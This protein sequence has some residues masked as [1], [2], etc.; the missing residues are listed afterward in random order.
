[1]ENKTKSIIYFFLVVNFFG[2]ANCKKSK[3]H[4]KST[5]KKVIKIDTI[6]CK[7]DPSLYSEII[8]GLLYKNSSSNVYLRRKQV[9]QKSPLG[10]E[11]SECE[12][13]PY[14]YIHIMKTVN[15]SIIKIGDV[16]DVKTFKKLS[17]TDVFYS[18]KN[19]IY[20]FQDSPATYPQFKE[21]DIDINKMVI[22]DSLYIKDEKNVYWKGIKIP[23]AKAISLKSKEIYTKDRKKIS[24]VYDGK[25]LYHLDKKYSIGQFKNLP[26]NNKKL[27]SLQSIYF[28]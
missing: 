11:L 18:D 3:T 9:V 4:L 25:S 28:K 6:K 17:N 13:I 7:N 1:M 10:G 15:D 26:L 21:I 22:L 24:L 27:D 12:K 20:V 14:G 16:I 5:L 8:S 19:S 2:F 23:K